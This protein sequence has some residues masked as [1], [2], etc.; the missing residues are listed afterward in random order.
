ME[1]R[2]IE[3]SVYTQESDNAA[4]NAVRFEYLLLIKILN[5]DFGAFNIHSSE[6]LLSC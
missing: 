4:L 1:N 3:L 2:T 6:R 5:F